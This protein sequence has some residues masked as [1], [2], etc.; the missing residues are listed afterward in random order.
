M[1]DMLPNP[2]VRVHASLI[3]RSELF[4]QCLGHRGVR[5]VAQRLPCDVRAMLVLACG[6]RLSILCRKTPRLRRQQACTLALR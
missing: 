5:P 3:S 6:C 4:D 1:A 2:E